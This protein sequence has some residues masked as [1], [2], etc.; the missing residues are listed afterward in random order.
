MKEK[1]SSIDRVV[2]NMSEEFRELVF[3]ARADFFDN[4]KFKELEGK[5]REKTPEEVRIISL[6]NDLTNETIKKYGLKDFDIPAKNIHIIEERWLS[7]K[8]SGIYNPTVQVVMMRDFRSKLAILYHSLH[9]MLHF[10]S[11]NAQQLLLSTEKN[12]KVPEIEN[13]RVGIVVISRDGRKGYFNNLNEAITEEMTKRII[14]SVLEH[15]LVLDETIQTRE[16]LPQLEGRTSDNGMPLT[17]EDTLY[18]KIEKFTE[19]D[20]E[21]GLWKTTIS[22]RTNGLAYFDERRI[23]NKL[24]DKILEKNSEQFKDRE[25][26]FEVFAK[27]MITGNILPMGRLIDGTFGRGTLRKIGELDADIEGQEK[28]VES[29]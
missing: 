15:P 2:G 20:K 26:V 5:E 28:F 11:Y 14:L 12:L 7:G 27:A 4:Q 16:I 8:A 22:A 29:L 23:L 24:M 21:S 3:K 6:A 9:E 13:Y 10:K 18:A 17:N 1:L 25:E 19:Q